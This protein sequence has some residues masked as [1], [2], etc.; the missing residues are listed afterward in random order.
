[1]TYGAKL[2]KR[3]T[4]TTNDYGAKP[5]TEAQRAKQFFA[6]ASASSRV[7]PKLQGPY[8]TSF[9]TVFSNSCCSGY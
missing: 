3:N 2:G 4:D 7:I 9:K 8:I 1:M 6:D 5:I